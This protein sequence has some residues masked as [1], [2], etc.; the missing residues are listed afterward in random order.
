MKLKSIKTYTFGENTLMYNSISNG[1]VIIS[2]YVHDLIKDAES[3]SDIVEI[4]TNFEVDDQEYFGCLIRAM[5]EN[6]MLEVEVEAGIDVIH[7]GIT[8][9]CNLSCTHCCF[10]AGSVTRDNRSVQVNKSILRKI[11][12]LNPRGITITGGEPL[13]VDDFLTLLR[14]LRKNYTG[15]ISLATNATLIHNFNIEELCNLI[16]TFDI[17]I[18]GIDSQSCDKIRG[19]GTFEVVINAVNLLKEHEAKNII[20]SMV[21]DDNTKVLDQEFIKMCENLG[22]KSKIRAMNLVGRAAD[23]HI[24]AQSIIRFIEGGISNI[25]GK[26]T[27]PGGVREIFINHEGDVYPCPLFTDGKYRI[28]SVFD[29]DLLSKMK[30]NRD[31]KWFNEFAEFLP[32]YRSECSGCE[33]NTFCWNCPSLMESFKRIEGISHLSKICTKKKNSI[34][35]A[36][37]HA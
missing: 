19:V 14:D 35:E 26:Y 21:F 25:S 24:G 23:N 8:D 9:K 5:T 22:V 3:I 7:Y 18:D 15:L 30:R 34:I 10:S 36:I 17:S 2:R 4:S 27:C 12:E 1:V 31:F 11:S 29:D 33:I 20:L 16:D 37:Q 32:E 28:G 13:L 6:R